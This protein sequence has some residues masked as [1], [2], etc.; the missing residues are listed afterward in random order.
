MAEPDQPSLHTRWTMLDRLQGTEAEAAWKW[1]IDRYR[2]FVSTCLRRVMGS[3]AA[4]ES[5]EDEVWSYLFTSDVFEQA[6][7]SRRFRGFLIGVIR[8]FAHSWR[9]R[10]YHAQA[11]SEE[12]S[13]PEPVAPVDLP[14][15]EEMRLF[16]CQ[17]LH[18]AMEE[19]GRKHEANALALRWFYGVP[20]TPNG[21]F[22]A[23][24]PVTKIAEQLGIAPNAVHQVLHRGRKRLRELIEDE[25]RETVREEVDL[26]DELE[27]MLG[28]MQREAPGLVG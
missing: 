13:L 7:R 4:A 8:N 27:L 6:D 2:P 24:M 25:L 26:K 11:A 10:N 16:A 21:E 22:V 12:D 15:D 20:D 14:E 3:K 19:L 9:R 18:L 28:A 17:V 1:F 5:A 23:A